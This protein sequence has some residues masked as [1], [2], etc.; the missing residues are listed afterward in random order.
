MNSWCKAAVIIF[1]VL[2]VCAGSYLAGEELG[3]LAHKYEP[4][5]DSIDWLK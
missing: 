1:L 2:L 5:A 3:R 4:T